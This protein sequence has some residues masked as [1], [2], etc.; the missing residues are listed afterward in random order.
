[1]KLKNDKAVDTFSIPVRIL[2]IV[3]HVV[4]EP[5]EA[6]FNLPFS[7]G[8]VPSSLKIA[9][10]ITVFKKGSRSHLNNYRSISPLSGI[11][12]LLGKLMC[13]RIFSYIDKKS[14]LCGKQFGFRTKHSTNHAILSI[15]DNIQRA[16][17]EK[18]FS[19][20]MFFDFSKAFGTVN[21]EIL[22]RKL[23]NYG[24]RGIT[25]DWF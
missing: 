12:K 20:G 24:I 3:R 21:H 16:I 13:K 7:I 25:N 1:M 19:C 17:E 10:V 2:K 11:N 22:V 15:V 14:I 9:K 8:I 18:E 5:L 4:S 6:I 23:E